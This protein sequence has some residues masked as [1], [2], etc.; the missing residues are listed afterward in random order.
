[1]V[2]E[3]N[4]ACNEQTMQGAPSLATR[5]PAHAMGS[6]AGVIGI[7]TPCPAWTRR[8]LTYSVPNLHIDGLPLGVLMEDFDEDPGLRNETLV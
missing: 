2:Y 7:R 8:Y 4:F 3:K 1:M 6:L 5:S